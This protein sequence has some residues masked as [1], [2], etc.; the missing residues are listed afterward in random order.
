M[1]NP[2]Y[3][4][5]PRHYPWNDDDDDDDDDDDGGGGGGGADPSHLSTVY[6]TGRP[7]A[8]SQA[9]DIHVRGCTHFPSHVSINL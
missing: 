9:L 3:Q 6:V 8:N 5:G 4:F 1:T 7:F 2:L